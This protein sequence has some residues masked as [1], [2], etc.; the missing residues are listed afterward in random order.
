MAIQSMNVISAIHLV[1]I[2]LMD[3]NVPCGCS[4][5]HFMSMDLNLDLTLERK[6]DKVTKWDADLETRLSKLKTGEK[7]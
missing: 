4:C 1:S 5:V 3:G 2:Q 7:L 6:S